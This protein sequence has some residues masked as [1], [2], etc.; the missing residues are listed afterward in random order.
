MSLSLRKSLPLLSFLALALPSPASAQSCQDQ[1]RAVAQRQSKATVS[2]AALQI[3][4]KAWD[5]YAKARQAA[6]TNNPALF[7]RETDL[8][9]K[10]APHF[11]D[12]YI[13]RASTQVLARHYDAAIADIA[14]A[15]L[16]DPD[17]PWSGIILTSALTGLGR[18]TDAV[19]ESERIHTSDAG[20]WQWAFERT[21]AEIGRGNAPA[22][23]HFSELTLAAAPSGCAETHLLRANA[24][25]LA[26][27]KADAILEYQ[28]YLDIPG[29]PEPARAQVQL[30]LERTR[31]SL[32]PPTGD[33]LAA[34]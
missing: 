3:P 15:R 18:Y 5:H 26:D 21:R 17:I 20:R 25:Q 31:K 32:Q 8:A 30:V 7:D 33:L 23:L 4:A 12:V 11:A 2:V 13:L 6:E 10:A 9:L 1:L 19:A 27:R 24:L 28:T 22:A 29:T 34:N 14:Q 16:L